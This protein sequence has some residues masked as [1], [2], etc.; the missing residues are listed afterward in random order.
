MELEAPFGL[1]G[2]LCR[3]VWGR[4][5]KELL[6]VELGGA[7]MEEVLGLGVKLLWAG[8]SWD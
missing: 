8:L 1:W 3:D 6:G 2:A 4:R 5:L 7:R